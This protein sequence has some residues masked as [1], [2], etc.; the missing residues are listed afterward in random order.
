MAKKKYLLAIR[1]GNKN[2]IT[3]HNTKHERAM[4][5]DSRAGRKGKFNY[6]FAER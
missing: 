3:I 1:E 6:A 2:T 4:I 5:L